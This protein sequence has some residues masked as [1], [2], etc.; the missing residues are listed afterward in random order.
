MNRLEDAGIIS[1][2]T[3]EVIARRVRLNREGVKLNVKRTQGSMPQV[4]V[5]QTLLRL[6][7][8]VGVNLN[9]EHISTLRLRITADDPFIL[10]FS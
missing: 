9:Y 3:E 6:P 2:W 4:I 8:I 1:Y 5:L 7:H 10:L